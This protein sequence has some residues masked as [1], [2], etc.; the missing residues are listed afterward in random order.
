MTIQ[1]VDVVLSV[2]KR[3][4][5][6]EPENVIVVAWHHLR[7]NFPTSI[8]REEVLTTC[9]LE[10]LKTTSVVWLVVLTR[11]TVRLSLSSLSML[12]LMYLSCEGTLE[13]SLW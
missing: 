1:T 2:H 7:I 13:G 3:C 5:S 12:M 6:I 8:L 11:V 4:V 10:Y 9:A